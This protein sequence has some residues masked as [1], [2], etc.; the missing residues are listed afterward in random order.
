MFIFFNDDV[1]MSTGRY[2]L[3]V[4]DSFSNYPPEIELE[5]TANSRL[6]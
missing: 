3:Q 1:K 4:A 6:F 5:V 2:K